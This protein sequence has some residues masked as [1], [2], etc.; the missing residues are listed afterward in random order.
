[1]QPHSEKYCYEVSYQNKRI[2]HTVITEQIDENETS[3]WG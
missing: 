2:S 3:Y 1:M